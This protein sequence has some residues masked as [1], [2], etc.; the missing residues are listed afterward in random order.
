M[1]LK[2][3]KQY[4]TQLEKLSGAKFTI[5]NQ[6]MAIESANV[7]FETMKAM[8]KGADAMKTIHGSM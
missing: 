8:E 2:R 5:E 7:N 3:K 4:E 1:A 6:V